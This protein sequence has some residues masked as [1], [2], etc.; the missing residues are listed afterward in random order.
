MEDRLQ[1]ILGM[2]KHSR[3]KAA[4]EVYEARLK[5]DAVQASLL[6]IEMEVDRILSQIKAE[7]KVEEER[8]TSKT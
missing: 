6:R 7:A 1:Q 8:W 5:N 4:T 2:I 3:E